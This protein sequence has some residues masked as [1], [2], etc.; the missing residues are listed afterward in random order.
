MLE[1]LRRFAHLLDLQDSDARKSHPECRHFD[2]YHITFGHEAQSPK[3][4]REGTNNVSFS[5]LNISHV[6][7]R[8]QG[9][10]E[11]GTPP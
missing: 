5:S 3:R 7:V 1:R 11:G 4:L 9:R 10:G 2:H 8:E 6:I